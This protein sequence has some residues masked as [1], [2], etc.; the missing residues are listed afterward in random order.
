MS[1]AD[2]FIAKGMQQLEDG[3]YK[4]ALTNFK[5][6]IAADP[7]NPDGYFGFAEASV[8][9]PKL[10]LVEVAQ[11]YKQAI[12]LDPENII[13]YTT[14]ADYCF[15][16]GLLPQGEQ[17]FL[18]AIEYDPDNAPFYYND[19]AYNYMNAGMKFMERVEALNQDKYD[20]M[21]KAVEYSLK[22]LDLEQD[23]AV[24]TA[25]EIIE[26]KPELGKQNEDKGELKKLEGDPE[27]KELLNIIKKEG[28]NPYIYVEIG[29][30]GFEK[31]LVRAGEDYFLKAV[32]IDPSNARFYIND[33]K[34]N[35]A[36]HAKEGGIDD[37]ECAQKCLYYTTRSLMIRPHDLVYVITGE[38]LE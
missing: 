1:E 2:E 12:E 18:K 21:R 27:V 32:E 7:K 6:A 10:S 22:A 15:S 13:Y 24:S 36:L 16:N 29:L 8:G 31:G 28:P 30:M 3:K 9:N 17:N 34:V 35:Y 25:K 5:K 20:V 11:H 14:Y 19:L 33:L 38:S 4:G 23:V 37:A 26:K